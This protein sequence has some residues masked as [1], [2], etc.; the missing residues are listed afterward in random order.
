MLQT[1]NLIVDGSNA[2]FKDI[3]FNIE[4][5][6]VTMRNMNITISD[7]FSFALS[8]SGT[9]TSNIRIVNCSLT[10]NNTKTID[11]TFASWGLTYPLYSHAI[12][13]YAYDG[14]TIEKN[15]INVYGPS[16]DPIKYQNIMMT[17]TAAIVVINDYRLPNTSNININNNIINIQNTTI[18]TENSLI[19]AI[20]TI[21]AENLT[22]TNNIIN[23]TGANTL[24]PINNT[25][26]SGT[27]KE[28]NNTIIQ[29]E[30]AKNTTLKV[31]TIS[32]TAGQT[33]TIASIYYGDDILT[34]IT[35]GKITFKVNG[36][37][38]KDENGKVIY[39]KVVNGVATIENYLVPT[40]WAKEGTTI[41]AIYSGSKQLEKL[42][43]KKT[44]ITITKEEPT[45][46]TEDITTTTG[47]KITLK[48]TITDNNK[49]I[50][51]GK[52][53]FKINGKTLKDEN[54]KVIY[55]KV[56]NNQV[57]LEYTLPESYKTGM[58]NITATF[59]S[60]D[61]DRL[62]DNKNLIVTN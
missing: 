52:V 1:N 37:T 49:V 53:V 44:E 16:I 2:T 19:N 45:L 42:T 28:E 39:A 29:E 20:V 48:A 4:K 41:Q 14:I 59:I 62:T 22:I 12:E 17:N 54:G 13:T 55:A 36:K 61:Y 23:I 25:N 5:T 60:P 18:P 15:V 21:N 9:N 26:N 33:T 38:L 46:T 47:G 7:K 3:C 8:I 51:N 31:D 50:N 30:E 6:N 43:S 24:T 40:D 34:N 10:I 57:V 58:Y 56:V 35:T 27:Y 11:D 32:F